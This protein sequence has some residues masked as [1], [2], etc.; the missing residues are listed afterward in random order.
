MKAEKSDKKEFILPGITSLQIENV[1]QNVFF[2]SGGEYVLPD[3][4]PKIEK[5]VIKLNTAIPEDEDFGL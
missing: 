3:Y 4:M 5:R 1:G 2:E